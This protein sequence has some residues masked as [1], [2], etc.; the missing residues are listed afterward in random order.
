[1][2]HSHYPG[3]PTVS[4]LWNLTGASP[5]THRLLRTVPP[6]ISTQCGA[7]KPQRYQG[8]A[9]NNNRLYIELDL[10]TVDRSQI[11]IRDIS[12]VTAPL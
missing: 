2:D 11:G 8:T 5:Y 4:A 1:M 3:Y 12:T 10:L 7:D 6:D 9:F